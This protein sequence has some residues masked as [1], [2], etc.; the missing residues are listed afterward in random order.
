MFSARNRLRVLSLTTALLCAG[1]ATSAVAQNARLPLDARGN[2]IQ[3]LRLGPN[4]TVPLTAQSNMVA[5]LDERAVVVLVVCSVACH[6]EQA[7]TP[8][9]ASTADFLLPANEILRLSVTGGVN[10]SIAVI[11]NTTEGTAYIVEM[12]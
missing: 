1:W 8:A 2:V 4:Q 11:A 3:A 6:I 12:R 7:A 9:T 10:D 5:P